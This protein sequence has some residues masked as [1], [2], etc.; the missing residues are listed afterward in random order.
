MGEE[1]EMHIYLAFVVPLEQNLKRETLFWLQE[2]GF[3]EA[4]RV[5]NWKTLEQKIGWHETIF[6]CTTHWRVFSFFDLVSST[7]VG[8]DGN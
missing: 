5:R 3:R 6:F 1:V 2:A 4:K 7:P 8:L